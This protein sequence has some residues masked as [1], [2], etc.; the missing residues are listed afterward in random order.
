MRT[1][2]IRMGLA[3]GFSTRLRLFSVILLIAAFFI[4]CMP[5]Y[6]G[7]GSVSQ[8]TLQGRTLTAS[9]TV[10]LK[11]HIEDAAIEISKMVFDL[12]REYGSATS[13]NMQVRIDL[14]SADDQ[15]ISARGTV[16]F[17]RLEITDLAQVRQCSSYQELLYNSFV[18]LPSRMQM[19]LDQLLKHG[20]G[21]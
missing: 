8:V 10:K 7:P 15:S 17:D 1:S 4:L 11:A 12:A 16:D 9:H 20:G 2:I 19:R 5:V 3:K 21:A 13:I 14:S 6:A 18:W